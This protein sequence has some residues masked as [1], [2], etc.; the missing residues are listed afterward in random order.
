MSNNHKNSSC[1][2]AETVVSYLYGES[3]Q[4]ETHK[5]Q[6][7]L[8]NCSP[9]TDELENFGFVRASILEWRDEEFSQLPTPMFAMPNCQSDKSLSVVSNVAENRSWFAEFSKLFAFNRATA[10]GAFGIVTVCIGLFWLAFNFSGKNNVAENPNDKNIAQVGISPTVEITKKPEVINDPE[11]NS[12]KSPLKPL[13]AKSKSA[14]APSK[15]ISK[16]SGNAPKNKADDSI[17]QP[18][19]TGSGVKKLT[20]IKKPAIPNLDDA[21]EEADETIRLADLFA[22]LDTK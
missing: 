21:E 1:P 14:T 5:F 16:V 9:C 17:R 8:E 18:E 4:V 7:H 10:M 12:E 13:E 3:N 22:E 20:S 11:E 15:T 2:F 6:A 19:N